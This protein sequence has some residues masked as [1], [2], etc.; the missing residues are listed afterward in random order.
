[1]HVCAPATSCLDIFY[2]KHTSHR[3][4]NSVVLRNLFQHLTNNATEDYKQP[5][6][7]MSRKPTLGSIVRYL[8]V[9]KH[10]IQGNIKWLL[11]KINKAGDRENITGTVSEQGAQ[12]SKKAQGFFSLFLSSCTREHFLRA[13]MIHICPTNTLAMSARCQIRY[14][15][16]LLQCIRTS[17]SPSLYVSPL[18]LP[19][20]IYLSAFNIKEIDINKIE[21]ILCWVL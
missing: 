1:M 2:I 11:S 9:P 10:R 4:L 21:S 14:A 20:D 7:L 8:A 6:V 18:H 3:L 12:F 15:F 5:L 16:A 19:L 13:E 17:L